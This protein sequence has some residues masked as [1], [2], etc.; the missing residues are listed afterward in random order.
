VSSD[1]NINAL[2]VE[3]NQVGHGNQGNPIRDTLVEKDSEIP[4]GPLEGL[5]LH[6]YGLK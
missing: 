4:A 6:L 2:Y 3:V 1:S 5:K